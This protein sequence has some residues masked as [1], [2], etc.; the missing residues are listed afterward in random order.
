MAWHHLIFNGMSFG[1]PF[2]VSIR[3]QK[4]VF[5][6]DTFPQC[7]SGHSKFTDCDRIVLIDYLQA[8]RNRPGYLR[9][10]LTR[11]CVGGVFIHISGCTVSINSTNFG[12]LERSSC[13]GSMLIK[14]NRWSPPIGTPI[15]HTSFITR[16]S[17]RNTWNVAI[18][19]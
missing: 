12:V 18:C 8:A 16:N 4:F 19:K 13:E 11:V 10:L 17:C 7:R 6:T 5:M 3:T 15:H 1:V 14:I 9:T 2:I